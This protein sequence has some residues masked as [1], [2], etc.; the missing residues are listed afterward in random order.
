MPPKANEEDG[1]VAVM[2]A[3]LLVVFVGAAAIAIDLGSAWETKRDLVTDTDAGALAGARLLANSGL[4]NCNSSSLQSA[5]Q[6]EA[7][8]VVALNDDDT[9]L[10]G[11]AEI[12]CQAS[13]AVVR[14]DGNLAAQQTFTGAMG[15]EDL[16]ARSL[17]GAVVGS[18][19]A[20][21]GL[22]PLAFCQELP[23][24]GGYISGGE[25]DPGLRGSEDRYPE[26]TF[27]GSRNYDDTDIDAGLVHRIEWDKDSGDECGEATGNWGWLSFHSKNIGTGNCN[28][29]ELDDLRAMICR[30]YGG[31]VSLGTEPNFNDKHCGI[32]D[33]GEIGNADE[34][35]DRYCWSRTGDPDS[36]HNQLR[37]TWLCQ[38]STEDCRN[39][40]K[41]FTVIVFDEAADKS[42]SNV[43]YQPIAFV[44]VILRDNDKD[45]GTWS[46][47]VE[48]TNSQVDG[49]VGRTEFNTGVLGYD[50]CMADGLENCTP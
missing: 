24:V 36:A 15:R 12:E 20:A 42:G 19:S 49:T 48:F 8:A 45:G 11:P 31:G 21:E 13:Y 44:G 27:N 30:G 4:E 23:A 40:G 41:V 29:S 26:S 6:N 34:K 5:V 16:G 35:E 9:I 32:V 3:I 22:L 25:R 37:S 46:M 10:N 7:A 43:K 14:V 18:V 39:N 33:E 17:S 38:E 47:D 28:G 50:L 2:V 1:A